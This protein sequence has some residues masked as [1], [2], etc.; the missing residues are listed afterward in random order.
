M[1]VPITFYSISRTGGRYSFKSRNAVS[2]TYLYLYK[3]A[4]TV[5]NSSSSQFHVILI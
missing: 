2:Q 3:A 4:A 1:D 5:S